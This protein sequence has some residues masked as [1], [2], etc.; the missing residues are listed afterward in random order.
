MTLSDDDKRQ[1]KEEELY[2][3][4]VRRDAKSKDGLIGCLGVIAI[5]VGLATWFIATS[6]PETPEQQAVRRAEQRASREAQDANATPES[7]PKLKVLSFRCYSEHTYMFISGEVKN[8]SNSKLKNV[9]AVGT[10]RTADGTHIT[11]ETALLE[12]NPIMPGQSSP[13]KAGG[14]HN[15]LM[16]KCS[17]GFKH[18]FG[19]TILHTSE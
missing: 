15:P 2:R 14:K 8:T 12:Y 9:V 19:G 10:F 11:T 18:L 6:E 16:A 1:I 5:I 7:Q 17:L 3:E 4:K 13:F